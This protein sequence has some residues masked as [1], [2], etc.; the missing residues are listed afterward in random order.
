[1]RV[2]PFVF[3]LLY[4]IWRQKLEK[5][6]ENYWQSTSASQW[7]QRLREQWIRELFSKL[8]NG[9][10]SPPSNGN[11]C[12]CFC[13]CFPFLT[14]AF[15]FQELHQSYQ[16]EWPKTIAICLDH[17]AAI[18]VVIWSKVKVLVTQS[19]PTLWNPMDYSLPGY[20][21]HSIFQARIL[22]WV[23]IPFFR[24]SFCYQT[25]V[26]HISGRLHMVWAT[27]ETPNLI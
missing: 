27:R 24:G 22:M 4:R 19:C 3:S 16:S 5:H 9:V 6:R 21:V 15:H 11:T 23:V 2:C 25:R 17:R 8:E 12:F 26:S 1:M 14:T 18:I 7:Y 13:F 10:L 20:T